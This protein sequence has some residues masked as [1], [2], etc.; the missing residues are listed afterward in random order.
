MITAV[1]LIAST[2][3]LDQTP[4]YSASDLDPYCLQFC[5][6]IERKMNTCVWRSEK[7]CNMKL[8]NKEN[9]K[10]PPWF[11]WNLYVE[12]SSGFDVTR[13]D[14]FD[15]TRVDGVDVTRV[16]CTWKYNFR[17]HQHFKKLGL[18]SFEGNSYPGSVFILV[19]LIT[20]LYWLYTLLSFHLHI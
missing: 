10:A 8:R 2:L 5:F 1:I 16:D 17:F 4:I 6:P 7:W 13:V 9:R 19:K 11:T 3:N 20:L 12:C 18:F 15:V 14:G